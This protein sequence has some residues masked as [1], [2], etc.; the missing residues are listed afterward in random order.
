MTSHSRGQ[1]AL[2]LIFAVVVLVAVAFVGVIGYKIFGDINTPLQNESISGFDN[3]TRAQLQSVYDRYPSWF[4]GMYVF[5]LGMFW[6][7][8]I[9]GSFFVR[10]HPIFF[11]IMVILLL[12]TFVVGMLLSN[13]YQEVVSNPDLADAANALPMT[14]WVMGHLLEVMLVMGTTGLIA[15]YAKRTV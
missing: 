5:T 11:I 10:S 2:D 7:G 4:D 9:I 15:L 6:I 1:I 14:N 12:I 8:M 13:V 3:Q